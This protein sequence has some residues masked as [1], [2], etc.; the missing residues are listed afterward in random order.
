M[1][2]VKINEDDENYGQPSEVDPQTTAELE[3]LDN[4]FDVLAADAASI[5]LFRRQPGSNKLAFLEDYSPELFR[6]RAI[7]DEFGGGDYVAI[8]K[9]SNGKAIKRVSFKVDTIF[10]ARVAEADK[11]V[12]VA[13]Q[14]MDAGKFLEIMLM[15]QKES[16]DTMMTMT[17]G[18]LSVMASAMGG[19]RENDPI[20]IVDVVSM[21]GQLKSLA[22]DNT[23]KMLN[24]LKQ[25][26]E[27]GQLVNRQEPEPFWKDAL[28]AI[29]P[30]ILPALGGALAPKLGNQTTVP[31]PANDK[32]QQMFILDMTKTVNRLVEDAKNARPADA[33]AEIVLGILEDMEK[34]YPNKVNYDN[35]LAF[36]EIENWFEMTL[37][38]VPPQVAE[39]MRQNKDWLT[40]VRNAMLSA[41]AE[42]SA[43][44]D[45]PPDAN[46]KLESN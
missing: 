8:G 36:L 27:M 30:A 3:G 1:P 4:A 33:E 45:G 7:R 5:Q 26:I 20:K 25:G 9:G 12:Q 29:A 32:E 11:P 13:G 40:A 2:K 46:G 19:R 39:I 43:V 23:E 22:P 28:K 44:N 35:C 15:Q 31:H 42:P 41:T 21:F 10:K 17:Q 16:R 37:P 6:L 24:V 18:M 34:K 38:Y 14:P